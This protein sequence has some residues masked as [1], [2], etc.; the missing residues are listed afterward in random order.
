[1]VSIV[2]FYLAL[3]ILAQDSSAYE[4]ATECGVVTQA[5]AEPNDQC[6]ATVGCKVLGSHVTNNL[7]ECCDVCRNTTGC[8]VWTLNMKKSPGTCWLR[9]MITAQI[10]K[11]FCT[12]G[13]LGRG[14]PPPA[15][16]PPA[17]RGAK[18]VLF[19]AIDD[20]RP[21]LGMY[22]SS[23][24]LSPHMDDLAKT[25]MVF[26]RMYTAVAVCGPARTAILVGR[27]PDTT[28]N[29]KLDDPAEYWR[30]TLPNAGSLPQ[31]FK[32]HGYV[33]LGQGK[34]FHPGA[35]HG[36]NDFEHS[37]SP[38]SLPY[39]TG[40]QRAA[41]S[42]IVGDHP[43]GWAIY[44]ISDDSLMLDGDIADHAIES[45]QTLTAR[46]EARP[47][48]MGV[49]F[50]KP[51]M[52]EECPSR[53]FDMY[54]LEKVDLPADLTPPQGAPSI[55]VQTSQQHR[56][57]LNLE[58][59]KG[60]CVE[61]FTAWA[62]A[63]RCRYSNAV[64]KD[65]RR[66]YWACISFVDAQVG[67][68][69]QKV[70][71]LGFYDSTVIVLFGD[72]GWH[73]GE[74]NMWAKYTNYEH[75]TRIPF[76]MHLAGQTEGQRTAAFVE[77]N[78]IFPSVVEAAGLPVPSLC[79]SRDSQEAYCV[80]GLSALPL[81]DAPNMVWKSAAFSQ[82]PRPF[83]GFPMPQP[84]LPHA[85]RLGDD[86]A[87][88]GYAC[89]E[90]SFRYVEW[91]GFNHSVALPDWSLIYGRE[92]YSHERSPVPDASFNY[93]NINL[94]NEPEYAD[95]VKSMSARLRLGWRHAMPPTTGVLSDGVL[96]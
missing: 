31:Y 6:E 44:N 70:K 24:V 8:S 41:K 42:S 84:D 93:E 1:M 15:P 29:W 35:L 89:R 66:A 88:M 27:R 53:Y 11:D 58:T 96:V 20:M 67:R 10:S 48:F 80:E 65:M 28:R 77:A 54:P 59:A 74:L 25:S 92:L 50:Y 52:P 46:K 47:F 19:F 34:I 36:F 30:N 37:W 94:A 18:N 39:Y 79:S 5:S 13:H 2:R 7:Q 32:E 43:D 26:D 3:S 17:P 82:Y 33:T 73:L 49:G 60:P 75:A 83:S 21:E 86:E 51:H 57:W 55:A 23:R 71:D 81:W 62:D 9:N 87:V 64:A 72:H 68:V 45:L 12:T 95:M 22:G 61:N 38:E 69:I 63:G 76:L 85:F 40:H 78:D 91:V 56:A 14:P 4:L 16:S 90:N